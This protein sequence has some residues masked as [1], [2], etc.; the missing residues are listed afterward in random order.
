MESQSAEFFRRHADRV[1]RLCYLLLGHRG[2]AEDAA[3]TVFLKAI[4][5]DMGFRSYEHEKAWLTVTARNHCRDVLKS[6]WRRRRVALDALPEIP[7]WSAAEPEGEVL[8]KLLSLPEKYKTVLYLYYFEEYSIKEIAELLGRRE[9]T[10]QTQLSRGR[11]R[12]KLDLGGE[13]L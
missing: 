6:S 9:S 5:A 12:L 2:D 10:V 8:A 4:Q 3:Q 13:W 1:Y 11:G 7:A